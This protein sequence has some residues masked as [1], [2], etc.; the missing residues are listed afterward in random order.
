MECGMVNCMYEVM[1][2]LF[3]LTA[4]PPSRLE[5]PELR[6]RLCGFYQDRVDN[7]FDETIHGDTIR[8]LFEPLPK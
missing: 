6:A 5:N 4:L 7:L 2:G 1:L 8:D 3:G